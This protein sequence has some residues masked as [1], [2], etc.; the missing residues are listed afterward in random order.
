MAG[1]KKDGSAIPYKNPSDDFR[2]EI[3]SPGGKTY[4]PAQVTDNGDGTFNIVFEQDGA[5]VYKVSV[6][7]DNE[8]ILN[9]PFHLNIGG[10]PA[11]QQQQQPQAPKPAG[12]NIFGRPNWDPIP[13]KSVAKFA[14]KPEDKDGHSLANQLDKLDVSLMAPDGKEVGCQVQADPEVG[15]IFQPLMAGD[16]KIAIFYNKEHIK[17]EVTRILPLFNANTSNRIIR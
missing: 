6:L 9:S 3:E 15:V 1:K 17:G 7:H 4:G 14:F 16:Y 8:H 13:G 11:P 10:A 2:V 5:G 12:T